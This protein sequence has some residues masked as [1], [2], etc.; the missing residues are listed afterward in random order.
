M[1]IQILLALLLVLGITSCSEEPEEQS[2]NRLANVIEGKCGNR[3]NC[4]VNLSDVYSFDWDEAF[5]F[6][7]NVPRDMIEKIVGSE[8]PP[9][10]YKE[11]CQGIIFLDNR[12]RIIQ[13]EFSACDREVYSYT[14]KG[15][16]AAIFMFHKAEE[17]LHVTK[18]DQT[19]C[20]KKF[21]RL[22]N[23]LAFY[24]LTRYQSVGGCAMTLDGV[25]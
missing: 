14:R 24:G 20:V 2:W 21:D 8:L 18:T 1:K 17:Y 6:H 16:P 15:G 22:S 11:Y 4:K 10:R 12:K 3:P 5:I 7:R 19:L 9:F 25:Y 23:D 13:T